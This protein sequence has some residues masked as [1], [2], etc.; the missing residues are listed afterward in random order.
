MGVSGRESEIMRTLIDTNAV[1][2]EAIGKVLA[3][4]GPTIAKDMDSEDCFC[5]TGRQNVTVYR[6]SHKCGCCLPSVE[7]LAQAVAKELRS[8]TAGPA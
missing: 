7:E 4:H 5:I 3:E 2:F 8:S 6:I 1:N